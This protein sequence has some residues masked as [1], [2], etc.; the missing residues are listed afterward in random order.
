MHSR[1]LTHT[2]ASR[3]PHAYA[4]CDPRAK[5]ARHLGEADQLVRSDRERRAREDRLLVRHLLWR[6][7]VANPLEQVGTDRH[8]RRNGGSTRGGGGGGGGGA[9]R[10]ERGV[11]R[12]RGARQR[13]GKSENGPHQ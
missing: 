8:A 4:S 1:A 2:G 12:E 13:R 7:H 10:R 3:A 6:R 5:A 9:W 11:Q